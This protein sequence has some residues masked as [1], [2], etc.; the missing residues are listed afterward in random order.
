MT[1]AIKAEPRPAAFNMS[2]DIVRATTDTELDHVRGLMRD[3]VAWHRSRHHQDLALINRYFDAATFNREL[4]ELPGVYAPPH[5]ALLI[6]YHRGQP[7]GCVALRNLGL[8][9]CEMKRMFV[10]DAYRGLGIG[11]ALA[12]RIMAQ[13]REVGYRTMRLDTSKRQAEAI[14]LYESCGFN[15]IEPYYAMPAEMRDWLVFYEREL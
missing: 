3:F 10:A 7:A 12:T 5:G 1:N 8:G 9:I 14:R 6:A 4:D 13:A 11:R 15:R 2:A